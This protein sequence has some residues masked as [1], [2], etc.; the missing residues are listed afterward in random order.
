MLS[1]L[2][3]IF[4]LLD[5][6]DSGLTSDKRNLTTS[7]TPQTTTLKLILVS[8]ACALATGV[9]GGLFSIAMARLNVRLRTVLFSAL[10]NQEVGFFDTT[11][12]GDITSRLSADTTTVSD[13]VCLN[14]NVMM[15]SLTQVRNP[16]QAQYKSLGTERI[17]CSC[18]DALALLGVQRNSQ[19]NLT[20]SL[21]L[22]FHTVLP[23]LTPD[24]W[25]FFP[26]RYKMQLA[27]ARLGLKLCLR[28]QLKS[29]A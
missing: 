27:P 18:F 4:K 28:A 26:F 3:T 1:F 29:C 5:L 21:S 22:A 6:A 16:S 24:P 20:P 13:Q 11:K 12:T 17:D 14:M 25:H 9:R 23:N 7:P 15:R 8:L 10:L 19:L 2:V